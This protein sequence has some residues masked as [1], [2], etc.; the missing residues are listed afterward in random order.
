LIERT[1]LKAQLLA[2]NLRLLRILPLQIR[3]GIRL[4]AGEKSKGIGWWR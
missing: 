3:D 4:P 1:D 2:L